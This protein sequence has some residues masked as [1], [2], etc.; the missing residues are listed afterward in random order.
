MHSVL[1]SDVNSTIVVKQVH[2]QI[3]N[4]HNFDEFLNDKEYNH[5]G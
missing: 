5:I 2:L 3:N 4:K 1:I